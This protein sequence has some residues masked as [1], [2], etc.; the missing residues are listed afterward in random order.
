VS[1]TR[2]RRS[3]PRCRAGALFPPSAGV[4]EAVFSLSTVAV[5]PF[6]IGMTL[7]PNSSA[8]RFLMRS[9]APYAALGAVFAYLLPSS[10]AVTDWNELI[11]SFS[12]SSLANAL[13]HTQSASM[14]W[15]HLSAWDLL[16]SRVCYWDGQKNNV[17]TRHSVALC[18]LL[19]PVGALSHFI[20][21]ALIARKRGEQL[22]EPTLQDMV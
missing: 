12:A 17:P 18:A 5:G 2:A 4:C 7:A 21:R 11:S 19:G 3:S 16:A 1:R 15:T 8:T 20:T 9:F 14:E 22:V 6:Y 13:S 10:V